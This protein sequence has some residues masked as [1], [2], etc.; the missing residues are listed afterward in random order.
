MRDCVPDNVTNE[1]NLWREAALFLT[2]LVSGVILLYRNNIYSKYYENR[3]I[4][5]RYEQS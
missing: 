3:F 4:V 1:A 2:N 5:S